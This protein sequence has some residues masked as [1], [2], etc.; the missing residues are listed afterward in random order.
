[1]GVEQPGG[2]VGSGYVISV[3]QNRFWGVRAYV[4]GCAPRARGTIV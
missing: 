2:V 3:V 4:A 1:M